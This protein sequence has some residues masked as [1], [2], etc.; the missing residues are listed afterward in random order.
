MGDRCSRQQ[1]YPVET[2]AR[3]QVLRW[4]TGSSTTRLKRLLERK[5][6]ERREVAA[7][8]RCTKLARSNFCNVSAARLPCFCSAKVRLQATCCKDERHKPK[9]SDGLSTSMSYFRI[10]AKRD[11]NGGICRT[12]TATALHAYHVRHFFASF[13]QFYGQC[14]RWNRSNSCYKHCHFCRIC[15]AC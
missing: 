13:M 5:C 6:C 1:R 3:A 9:R 7:P 14:P 12:A 4:A 2:F 8:V 15:F 10:A 11:C